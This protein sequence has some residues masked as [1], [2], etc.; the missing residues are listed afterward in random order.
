MEIFAPFADIF[1]LFL[2]CERRNKFI[3]RAASYSVYA[4]DEASKHLCELIVLSVAP[5]NTIHCMT[6]SRR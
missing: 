5:R 4:S 1:F 3:M 2:K 6:A